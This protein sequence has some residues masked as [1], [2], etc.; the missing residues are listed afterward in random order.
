MQDCNHKQYSWIERVNKL[1]CAIGNSPS[2]SHRN[3]R[4]TRKLPNFTYLCKRKWF[5][6][7]RTAFLFKV[8]YTFIYFSISSGLY[9]LCCLE[10]YQ[11]FRFRPSSILPW[12]VPPISS[13]SSIVLFLP[14]W[15]FQLYISLWKSPSTLI[16][17]VVVD[18]NQ[19]TNS[20]TH[21]L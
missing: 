18:W 3:F 8:Q 1:Q 5:S 20:L 10:I 2:F 16:Q 12:W 15:S 7:G 17:S 21:L 4:N 19:N 6:E 9:R 13:S 11:I 14:Y